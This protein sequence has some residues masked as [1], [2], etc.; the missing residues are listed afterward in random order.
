M[1]VSLKG[2]STKA[3][4]LPPLEKEAWFSE[5]GEFGTTGF[6][7]TSRTLAR[8]VER[9]LGVEALTFDPLGDH[10]RAANHLLR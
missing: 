2:Q 3:V 6:Q 10:C 8:A 5:H 4:F 9:Q 1:Q 7:G